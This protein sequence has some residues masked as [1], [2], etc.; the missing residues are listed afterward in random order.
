MSSFWSSALSTLRAKPT[1]GMNFVKKLPYSAA[2]L[3]WARENEET[4]SQWA[5]AGF[6]FAEN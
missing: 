6:L 4:M 1:Q 3:R 2:S 5:S